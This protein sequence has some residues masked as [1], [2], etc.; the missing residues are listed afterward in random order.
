MVGLGELA[1]HEKS[2]LACTDHPFRE[3]RQNNRVVIFVVA[4]KKETCDRRYYT[5]NGRIQEDEGKRAEAEVACLPFKFT[6]SLVENVSILMLAEG[7]LHVDKETYSL[8][9]VVRMP[10]FNVHFH[11][12]FTRCT[13]S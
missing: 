11:L 5:P 12:F 4:V 3:R 7:F 2:K 9:P 13:L 6:L 10:S 8:P 1:N